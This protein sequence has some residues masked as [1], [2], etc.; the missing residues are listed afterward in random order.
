M[1]PVLSK[2]ASCKSHR[3]LESDLSRVR[4]MR[5]NHTAIPSLNENS[6]FIICKPFGKLISHHRVLQK[7]KFPL[8]VDEASYVNEPCRKMSQYP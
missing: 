4:E 5:E 7:V 3:P 2:T 8:D 1:T 6:D